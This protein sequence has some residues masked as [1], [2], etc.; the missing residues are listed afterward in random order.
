MLL[1]KLSSAWP[2]A[3][4]GRHHDLRH[5]GNHFAAASGASLRDLMAR[6]GHDSERAAIIYQH[7]ARGADQ[8]ITG[9]IDAHIEK[10]T[11]RRGQLDD[12]S[13]EA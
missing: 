9:A 13:T 8:V 11:A 12:R 10:A 3:P 1:A 5:T 2:H 7:E 6:M 4:G